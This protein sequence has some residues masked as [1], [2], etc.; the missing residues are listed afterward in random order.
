MKKNPR[1]SHSLSLSVYR[2]QRL[3]LACTYK[4]IATCTVRCLFTA[5]IAQKNLFL[6]RLFLGICVRG[7]G[8]KNVDGCAFATIHP[9]LL[10]SFL[11][12]VRRQL[13]QWRV[14]QVWVLS[15]NTLR[16]SSHLSYPAEPHLALFNIF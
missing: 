12:S 3:S 6:G 10:V 14:G 11:L 7:K 15:P 13:L 2:S 16:F 5:F 9:F 4:C 8:K 1:S